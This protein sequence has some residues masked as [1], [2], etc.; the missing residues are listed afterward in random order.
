MDTWI[1]VKLTACMGVDFFRILPLAVDWAAMAPQKALR[2][3]ITV[4]FLKP[5][6]R[7]WSHFW[8]IYRQKLT[9]SLKN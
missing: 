5:W 4:S 2:E 9:R 3:G 8:G 6:C 1:E 7:S